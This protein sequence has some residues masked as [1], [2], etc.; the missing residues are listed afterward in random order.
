MATAVATNSPLQ[1]SQYANR[2]VIDS[3]FGGSGVAYAAPAGT[4]AFVRMLGAI[5]S[6]ASTATLNFGVDTRGTS[7]NGSL[8]FATNN[9]GT[10]INDDPADFGQ[11]PTNTST[12]IVAG[13]SGLY[14]SNYYAN[15]S[16][17]A[18][19]TSGWFKILPGQTLTY[20]YSAATTH[21][22]FVVVTFV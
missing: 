22:R 7:H 2:V 10:L 21:I 12:T 17:G 19:S 14:G 13:D 9:T 1:F 8:V 15:A 16:V 6:S 4:V 11:W 18:A 3:T 5:S 20:S